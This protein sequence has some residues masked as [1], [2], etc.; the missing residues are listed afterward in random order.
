MNE[1]APSA[2]H[3]PDQ[4]LNRV[5]PTMS[6]VDAAPFSQPDETVITGTLAGIDKLRNGVAHFGITD[7]LNFAQEP[8]Q[9]TIESLR[10]QTPVGIALRETIAKLFPSF[11]NISPSLLSTVTTAVTPV[12]APIR[13]MA[14]WTKLRLQSSPANG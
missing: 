9:R 2:P 4:L 11:N 13:E 3:E 14:N 10:Q 8:L 5:E 1:T 7:M 6:F 12:S